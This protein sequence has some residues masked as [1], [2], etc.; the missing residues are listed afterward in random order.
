MAQDDRDS[1]IY[2]VTFGPFTL[3]RVG[4]IWSLDIGS[5]FGLWGIIGHSIGWRRI[6]P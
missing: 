6:E 2:C 4:V 1:P 3:L 5:R